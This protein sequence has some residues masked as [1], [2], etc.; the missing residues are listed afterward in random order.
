MRCTSR[1]LPTL[2]VL[3]LACA[4]PAAA[5]DIEKGR[6]LAERLCAVCHLNPGQGEK[7]SS[8]EIP[9]FR[10]I[11]NRPDQSLEGIVLWLE[12]VPKMMPDHKLS[13]DERSELAV[14]IMSLRE[15]GK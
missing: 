10:A 11:A 7:Q 13:L 9:G 6:L 3:L 15:E 5:Q 4:Q 14:Y 8:S 1:N 12:S 2:L